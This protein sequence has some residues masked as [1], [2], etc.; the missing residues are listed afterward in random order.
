MISAPV[1]GLH[2]GYSTPQSS[3]EYEEP[4]GM[5]NAAESRMNERLDLRSQVFELV[6]LLNDE[7]KVN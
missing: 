7:D 2:S 1:S 4:S 5:P 3:Y 6:K